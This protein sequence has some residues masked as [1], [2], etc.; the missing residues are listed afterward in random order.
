M[1]QNQ[2]NLSKAIRKIRKRLGLSQDA[3]SKRFLT[4]QSAV[5]RWEVGTLKPDVSK[6]IQL[7]H[8]A[9]AKEE[10][11]PIVTALASRSISVN[12]LASIATTASAVAC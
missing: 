1:D 8:L 6:L 7:L 11:V 3:F 4:A 2:K 5:S 12:D 10:T 9:E